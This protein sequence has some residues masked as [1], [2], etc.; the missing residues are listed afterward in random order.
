MEKSKELVEKMKNIYKKKGEEITDEKAEESA[1]H[2]VSLVNFIFEISKEE[3]ARKSR[4]KREPDGFP[5]DVSYSCAVCRNS[6]NEKTGW[7]SKYGKTCFYCLRALKDK[8]IPTYILDDN[9]THFDMSSL[10]YVFKIKT[11]TAKK[12]IKEGKLIPRIILDDEG[13]PYHYIFLKKENPWLIRKYSP[14]RKSYDRHRHKDIRRWSIKTQKEL[15]KEH[16]EKM[17]RQIV[18]DKNGREITL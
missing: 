1:N 5:V 16:R 11:I 2:L 3:S 13:N 9:D 18:R 15:M 12:Y 14:V 8:V 17:R 7:Y 4:L 10:N 6:I